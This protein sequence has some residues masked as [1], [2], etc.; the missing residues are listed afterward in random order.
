[1]TEKNNK[2]NEHESDELKK[3]N[4]IKFV[5]YGKEMIEKNVSHSGKSGRI[6]LPSEWINS[7]V[8]IIRM[9]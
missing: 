2:S 7:K 1:M 6:Y 5:F 4:M 3:S 9:E 8:K